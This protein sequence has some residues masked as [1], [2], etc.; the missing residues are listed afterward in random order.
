MAQTHGKDDVQMS[1]E[2]KSPSPVNDE[3]AELVN[4][5][6]HVQELDRHFNL[7]TLAGVGLVVGNVWPALGGSILVAIYNGGPPGVLYEF[8]TVSIFYWIV[9][10]SIAELASAIPSSSGVYH[11]AS[12]TPGRSYGRVVGFFAGYWNWLAWVFGVASMSA[13]SGNICVQ[14]YGL[15]HPDF[16]AKPWHVFVAYVIITWCACLAVCFGNRIMPHLNGVGIFFILSGVFVTVVVCAAMP[17]HGGRPPHATSAFV[18]KDWT[19]NIGYPDGFTFLAGM[20][21]GAYAVGTPD[22]VA[23]LAEE[24]PYPQTNV[25]KAI[26]LQMGIGFLT[27]LVYLIATLYAISDYNNL[28]TSVFPIAEIYRQAT[29]SAA[30]ST[31]LLCLLL[32]P[33]L[34]CVTGVYIT[35]GRTLWTLGRDRAT[36]FPQLIGRVDHRLGMPF[37]ATITCGCVATILGCIYVGSTTAF[38]AFVGSFVLMT[39]ASYTA[40]ILPNLITRRKNI[41]WGPFHMKGALGFVMNGIAVA[42][43]VVWFVIYCFPFALPT[44][45]ASMNYACLIFGGLTILVAVWWFVGAGRNGYEGP[46][47]M[48]GVMTGVEDVRRPSVADVYQRKDSGV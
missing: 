22:C 47:T 16:E 11:W 26:A 14:M 33:C 27:G 45:A 18:W 41:V 34:I 44:T 8:I 4:A 23:H 39:T 24:I 36:P 7:L 46:K 9:A 10:A 35:S 1:R 48:G 31:G 19:A 21:N 3:K 20:L 29:G 15:N 42:Y 13:I 17:G 30:G 25:P 28:F 40:A 6:G 38:N 12:V 5:S 32:F 43:M 37:A 2:D